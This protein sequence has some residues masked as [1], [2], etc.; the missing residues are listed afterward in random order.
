MLFRSKKKAEEA[1]RKLKSPSVR[2]TPDRRVRQM[3]DDAIQMAA[4][5]KVN[6]QNS[7]HL[8]FIDHM[9]HMIGEQ[10]SADA[11][12]TNFQMASTTLDAGAKIYSYRVD[13]V[14]TQTSVLAPTEGG[15]LVLDGR[16]SFMELVGIF[17]NDKALK[18]LQDMYSFDTV[19]VVV[20]DRELPYEM[21]AL[22]MRILL[23]MHM[24]RAPL[25]PIQIPSST[26]V[27]NELPPFI[28]EQY[29]DPEIGRA[30]V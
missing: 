19:K 29:L 21:R 6:A 14:V 13:S 15:P 20:K 10:S 23:H 17:I 25:E 3:Y 12:G 7:W 22:F 27:W 9:G 16:K 5:D 26:G 11:T 24:E 4:N 8:D 30:H 1:A 18:R 28:K 2:K